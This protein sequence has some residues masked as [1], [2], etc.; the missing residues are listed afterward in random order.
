MS[1]DLLGHKQ[2]RIHGMGACSRPFPSLSFP[3][4]IP[5][6]CFLHRDSSGLEQG[7]K[8]STG[9][10]SPCTAFPQF[11]GFF[12]FFPSFIPPSVGREERHVWRLKPSRTLPPSRGKSSGKLLFVTDFWMCLSTEQPPPFNLPS[13]V[14]RS[15]LSFKIQQ[16]TSLE[17]KLR[18]NP[19]FFPDQSI[20]RGHS[21]HPGKRLGRVGALSRLSRLCYCECHVTNPLSMPRSRRENKRG[22]VRTLPINRSPA[23]AGPPAAA[24]AGLMGFAGL[25]LQI[26]ALRWSLSI[27]IPPGHTDPLG[28]AATTPGRSICN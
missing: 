3:S 24:G 14:S 4:G 11:G 16:K 7:C 22:K 6:I 17:A 19:P 12:S 23:L 21:L 9:L 10:G 15:F 5:R 20:S 28:K 2:S 1:Q 8:P 26:L 18:E 25:V 13:L 27:P